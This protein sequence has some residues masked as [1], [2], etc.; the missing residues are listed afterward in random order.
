MAVTFP[1]S[2]YTTCPHFETTLCC[3][4]LGFDGYLTTLHEDTRRAATELKSGN[5]IGPHKFATK[6]RHV[7]DTNTTS[8][9]AH[10]QQARDSWFR[11][12]KHHK[13]RLTSHWHA[14]WGQFSSL[15]F[16]FIRPFPRHQIPL[17]FSWAQTEIE[18][19]VV[20]LTSVKRP[21]KRSLS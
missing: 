11:L 6:S 15:S 18:R 13:S 12:W 7:R 4:I 21:S 10:R 3:K 20:R 16:S 19:E 2:L 14:G 17:P 1:S 5:N 9:F 8:N